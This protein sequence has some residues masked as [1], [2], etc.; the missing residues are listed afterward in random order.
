MAAQDFAHIEVPQEVVEKPISN[1]RSI[2]LTVLLVI[3]ILGAFTG[4]FWLGQKQGIEIAAGEDKARLE[5]LLQEKQAEMDALR[6]EAAKDK[7]KPKVSTTQVGE[8]TFYNELPSQSVQ[9]TPLHAADKSVVKKVGPTPPSSDLM[10]QVIED[11]MNQGGVV[12]DVAVVVKAKPVKKHADAVVEQSYLLQ[13][14]S[15]QQQSDANAFLPKLKKQGFLP[16]VHRVELPSLGVWYRVYIGPYDSQESAE[17]AKLAVKK[18]LNITSL[19]V[20][21]P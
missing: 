1:A 2:V 12:E 20:K 19:L 3:L 8:L 7:E 17:Q 6:A 9:P 4:G 14:G 18:T 10:R 5:K 15:F 11:E 16:S 21:Q 13:V